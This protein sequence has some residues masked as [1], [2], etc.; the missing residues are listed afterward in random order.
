[1]SSRVSVRGGP[2]CRRVSPQ[3]YF[4]CDN[5]VKQ[6]LAPGGQVEWDPTKAS[7]WSGSGGS[8]DT[9]SDSALS[10]TWA[11]ERGHLLLTETDA[12][13]LVARPC[14]A[15]VSGEIS[16]RQWRTLRPGGFI[17]D[18]LP[19]LI[20]LTAP[21]TYTPDTH[22]PPHTRTHRTTDTHRSPLIPQL[23]IMTAS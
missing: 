12:C 15:A 4:W 18:N 17:R 20:A 11:P 21:H 2:D 1:M 9:S 13:R 19:H 14:S 22:T 10:A 6:H 3:R 5:Q 8:P 16:S 7:S 23:Q